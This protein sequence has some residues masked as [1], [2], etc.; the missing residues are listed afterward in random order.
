MILPTALSAL[1]QFRQFIAYSLVPKGNGK[2]DKVP[3]DYRTGQMVNAHDP[4]YWAD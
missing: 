2:S 3:Y 1:G 4:Q